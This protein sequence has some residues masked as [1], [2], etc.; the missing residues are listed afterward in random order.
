MKIF[1]K[2]LVMLQ[3]NKDRLGMLPLDCV[4]KNT[5]EYEKCGSQNSPSVL[6]ASK[7]RSSW[8]YVV[9]HSGNVTLLYKSVLRDIFSNLF[10]AT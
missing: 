4:L 1:V 2:A 8:K 9:N 6:L 3:Q 10:L 5:I 7:L